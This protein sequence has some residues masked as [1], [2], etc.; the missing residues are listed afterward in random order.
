MKLLQVGNLLV[1]EE[2]RG[3]NLLHLLLLPPL[4]LRPALHLSQRHLNKGLLLELLLPSVVAQEVREEAGQPLLQSKQPAILVLFNSA[5][6]WPVIYQ[7]VCNV[8][9]VLDQ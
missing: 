2:E 1:E 8:T 5:Y 7:N 4:A 9:Q 3:F 6:A